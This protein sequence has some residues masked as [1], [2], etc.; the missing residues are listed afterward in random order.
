MD[1]II[2]SKSEARRLILCYQGLLPPQAAAGKEAA[3]A[4]VQ[5][6]GCIQY[7]PLN[8][9]GRN[10]DLV[11]Q[12]RISD[13]K[14][15]LL[16]ELLYKDRVLVDGWDKN[17]SIYGIEDWPYFQRY[18]DEAYE[19]YNADSRPAVTILP[20][21]RERIEQ[22]GPLSSLDLDF[23][24]T[25]DWSW[26]PT[27]MARAALE[28]MYAWGEVIIHHRVNTRKM[29]DFAHRHIPNE[30]LSADDP[31]ETLER[32]WEWR[33][34]RRIAAIGLIW[35]RSGDAWL[36][37][38]GLK[39]KERE[40][41]FSRLRDGGLVVGVSV[42]GMKEPLYLRNV[43]RGLLDRTKEMRIDHPSASIIAPLD[44]LMWDR[45]FIKELFDFYYIWEVYKP[46]AE[47]RFG[48]YVLPILYGD[49]FIARFEPGRDKESGAM[50]IKNWWWESGISQT[51]AM[52]EAL[53]HCFKRFL[54]YL[55]SDMLWIA[56]EVRDRSD[57]TWLHS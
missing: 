40:A 38:R 1:E 19:R 55:D 37:I 29:Y 28:S 18:R 41:A 3:H 15:L 35:N 22:Q 48:Y 51:K 26:G 21:V 43:D 16:D 53:Q 47:R 32:F 27:R 42:E 39:A 13:F 24:Q 10:P 30:I 46:V 36:G 6:L 23:D 50:L 2:L 8:I 14:P 45:R 4:C 57:I 17:M 11:L 52:R 31:N 7:D 33:V 12:A 34:L 54:E 44:N 20:E 49:R 56:E 5:R 25:V 9:V